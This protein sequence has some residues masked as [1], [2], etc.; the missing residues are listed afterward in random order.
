MSNTMQAWRIHEFGHEDVLHL[1]HVPIPVPAEGEVLIKVHAAGVNPVD[2]KIREGYLKD[3]LPHQLPLILG[4]D[5]AGEII[6]AGGGVTAFKP[7]DPVY[8]RPDISRDGAYGEYI[9]VRASEIAFKPKRLSYVEAAAIPLAGITAWESL[10]TVA[11]I[12]AGQRV[13]IHAAAGG[14]GSLAVQIAKHRGT[15]VSGTCSAANAELVESLGAD[16]VINYQ[17]EPFWEKAKAMDVVFDTIGGQTQEQ[18][19]QTLKPGGLLVSVIDPPSE[20][21][22]RSL[23]RRGAFV[24]IQPNAGYLKAMAELI[25]SGRLKPVVGQVF[26]FNEAKAA[27]RLSQSGHAVGKIV[28]SVSPP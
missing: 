20:D 23:G 3:F 2:W 7:G 18:S 15:W 14:V 8:S 22:A 17:S 28:L 27:L 26:P 13:L 12:T 16:D 24:F 9:V 21:K 11:G 4:W 25:D 10:V 19:W 5:V 6:R 1:D